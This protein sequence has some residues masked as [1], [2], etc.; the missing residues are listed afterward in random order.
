M[1]LESIYGALRALWHA[2]QHNKK[3]LL[4]CMAGQNRSICV[5]DCYYFLRTGKHRED[6]QQ[7]F[8]SYGKSKYNQLIQ[9]I[10]DNQLPG[11]F[12]MEKFLEGCREV[13]E[14]PGT[15]NLDDIKRES[16]YSEG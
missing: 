4:H 5:A 9:N 12:R 11:I 15:V 1:P 6:M 10:N 14:E 8:T 2:E 13:L 3:A 7:G 16:L